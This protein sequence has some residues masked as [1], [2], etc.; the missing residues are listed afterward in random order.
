MAGDWRM[1]LLITLA[2]LVYMEF[3]AWWRPYLF[4]PTPAIVDKL[5]PNWE[6]T[7]AFL[8]ERHGIRPNTMHCVMHAATVAG[9]GFALADHM[10]RSRMS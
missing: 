8:P 4:G 7:Y 10:T 5:R 6:G 3:R 2:V 9:F 1:T